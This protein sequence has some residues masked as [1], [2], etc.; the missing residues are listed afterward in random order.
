MPT[1]RLGLR[2]FVDSNFIGDKATAC[3]E[4]RRLC[5]DGMIELV[6]TDVV[7]TELSDTKDPEKRARL[8]K[9]S[10]TYPELLGAFMVGDSRPSHWV[11]GNDDDKALFASAFK[12]LFPRS[13]PADRTTGRA[14]RKRRD[15]MQI[16]GAIRYGA[17]SN[18]GLITRDGDMLRRREALRDAFP[19][20]WVFLP[21]EALTAA[22]RLSTRYQAR[23]NA[24]IGKPG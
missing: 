9:E 17:V 23:Q 24:K 10:A 15:A 18:G 11:I 16:A 21:E 22:L 20:F 6:R 4:L 8:L 7:D 19:S 14:R 13:D 2:F 1:N 12:I 3:D 5:N